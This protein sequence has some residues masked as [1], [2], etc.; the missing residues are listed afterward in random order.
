MESSEQP[1]AGTARGRVGREPCVV[2]PYLSSLLFLEGNNGR[3]RPYAKLDIGTGVDCR[4]SDFTHQNIH[5]EDGIFWCLANR[6]VL[7]ELGKVQ[8]S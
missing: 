5:L 3:S 1:P 2:L 6:Y 4:A 7:C 8:C